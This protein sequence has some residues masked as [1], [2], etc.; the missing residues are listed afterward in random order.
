MELS[1]PNPAD[2]VEDD[3]GIDVEEMAEDMLLR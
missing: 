3:Q 1:I 2:P